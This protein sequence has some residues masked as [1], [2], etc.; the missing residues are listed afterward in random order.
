V[1]YLVDNE[2]QCPRIKTLPKDPHPTSRVV[3]GK[4]NP[5]TGQ[6]R[7]WSFMSA[8][9]TCTPL[10]TLNLEERTHSKRE[11]SACTSVFSYADNLRRH[12]KTQQFLNEQPYN[13]DSVYP[14][15]NSTRRVLST[16]QRVMLRL[17]LVKSN[18]TLDSYL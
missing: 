5:C 7:K 1:L 4:V 14:E 6:T 15:D 18:R 2:E 13:V 10:S 16:N 11:P 8:C 12:L 3:R 9:K 17:C